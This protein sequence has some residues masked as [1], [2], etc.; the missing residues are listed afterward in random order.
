MNTEAVPFYKN[1]L[2][3]IGL[4][5][6]GITAYGFINS[7]DPL[8]EKMDKINADNAANEDRHYIWLDLFGHAK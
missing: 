4:A 3:Y 8:L 7:G 6:I 2:F 5:V 1:P